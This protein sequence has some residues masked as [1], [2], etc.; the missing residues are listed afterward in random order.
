MDER[1]DGASVG[2]MLTYIVR[3]TVGAA[4]LSMLGACGAPAG[5]GDGAAAESAETD[6]TARSKCVATPWMSSSWAEDRTPFLLAAQQMKIDDV[7]TMLDAGADPSQVNSDGRSALHLLAWSF[8][9]EGPWEDARIAAIQLL[10]SRGANIN[11]RD[12]RGDTPLMAAAWM[13]DKRV[14]DALL[15]A[16]ADTKIKS[17][18]GRT[19]VWYATSNQNVDIV[20]KLLDAGAPTSG[21]D[22]VTG[23][24]ALHVAARNMMKPELSRLLIERGAAPNHANCAGDTPLLLATTLWF[25][26]VVQGLLDHGADP[27]AKND[28]GTTPLGNAVELSFANDARTAPAIIEA[29]LA[30][31]RLTLDVQSDDAKGAL[32]VLSGLGRLA[33]VKSLLDRGVPPTAIYESSSPVLA[34]ARGGPISGG[35]FAYGGQAAIDANLAPMLNL[36]VTRG[37]DVNAPDG[38]PLIHATAAQNLTKVRLLTMKH[39]D[40]NARPAGK[41]PALFY[42][43]RAKIQNQDAILGTLLGAGAD[44]N[45]TMGNGVTILM[46]TFL[47][48]FFGEGVPGETPHQ[49]TNGF[50]NILGAVSDET[51]WA[52]ASGASAVE[53]AVNETGIDSNSIGAATTAGELIAQEMG[54]RLQGKPST[55]VC[56]AKMPDR[57][58]TTAATCSAARADLDSRLQNYGG[59]SFADPICW[60]EPAPTK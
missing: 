39:A 57:V 40:P 44:P 30:S 52:K 5:S 42:A 43:M 1:A 59:R 46:Y 50:R 3:A 33:S 22:T 20:Q 19:A 41:A 36:L 27:N 25:T 38:A 8:G 6:L 34:W 15:A 45:V 7:R 51:L 11:L 12:R 13:G 23:D 53:V 29:L 58:R 9:E 28:K 24:T 48:P 35:D 37:A 49:V 16:G 26:D 18:L 47:S 60:Q 2:R 10:L 4:V 14:V 32:V 55:C 56:S 21:Y 54:R 31:P 17:T